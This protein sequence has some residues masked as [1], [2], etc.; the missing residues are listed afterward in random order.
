MEM[1]A[2]T[3]RCEICDGEDSGMLFA[4]DPL[5]SVCGLNHN[6]KRYFRQIMR[7]DSFL[8]PYLR[9]GCSFFNN[10]EQFSPNNDK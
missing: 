2:H 1:C 6:R 5:L 4:T 9:W 10:V 3:L 7:F 8:C